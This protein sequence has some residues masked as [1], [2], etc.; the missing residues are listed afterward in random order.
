MRRAT[1][2][3]RTGAGQLAPQD[4]RQVEA[5]QIVQRAA[6]QIGLDQLHIQ[7]TGIGHGLEHGGL[8]DGVEG[9]ALDLFVLQRLLLVQ[10]FQNMPADRLSLTVGVGR[11]N[12]A[13][14]AL[15][16]LR[17]LGQAFGRLGVDLP[18]HGEIVVGQD[19]AVLGRQVADMAIGG[20]NLIVRTQVFID[21][22]GLGGALDDDEIHGALFGKSGRERGC[23]RE[24]SQSSPWRA[25]P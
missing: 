20:Q 10:D 11:E 25:C 17:N 1:D 7:L 23:H 21:G 6:G 16:R 12:N 19:G 4:G 22:L 14:G 5:H 8:G 13:V 24:G 9:D 15:G 18:H 3:T 2:C